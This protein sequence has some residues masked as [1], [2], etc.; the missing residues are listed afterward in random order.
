MSKKKIKIFKEYDEAH[1][2]S[3]INKHRD[4]KVVKSSGNGQKGWMVI[5]KNKK[6]LME[7]KNKESYVFSY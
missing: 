2:F 4:F 5:L 1:I 3:I 7:E 6:L